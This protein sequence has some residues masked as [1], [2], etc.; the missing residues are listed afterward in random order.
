MF[1]WI[2]GCGR[3]VGSQR[4]RSPMDGTGAAWGELI[5]KPATRAAILQNSPEPTVIAAGARLILATP[6][7][8]SELILIPLSDSHLVG[9]VAFA[10]RY[11]ERSRI[12]RIRI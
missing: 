10:I 3:A 5:S 7:R 1:L 4:F 9:R 12:S 11:P 6:L 8:G 2:A